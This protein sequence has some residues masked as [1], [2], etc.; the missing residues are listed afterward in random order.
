MSK[1]PDDQGLRIS[2]VR[3]RRVIER[4]VPDAAAFLERAAKAS[5]TARNL[6]PEPPARNRVARP[7][8]MA[9]RL[10]LATFLA[11]VT[12]VMVWAAWH[13]RTPGH[14]RH[15]DAAEERLAFNTDLRNPDFWRAPTDFLLDV[16]GS[17]FLRTTPSLVSFATPIPA[18]EPSDP[19]TGS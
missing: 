19:D 11:L 9:P 10:A 1:L 7:R 5:D 16:P 6:T 2:F 17:E 8:F 13:V 3:L 12:I 4:H 18:T 14:R 15:T